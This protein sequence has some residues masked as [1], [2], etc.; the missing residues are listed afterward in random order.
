VHRSEVGAVTDIR[1]KA[2]SEDGDI[3]AGISES[4]ADAPTPSNSDKLATA[5]KIHTPIP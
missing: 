4:V 2:T 1:T 3:N 5:G